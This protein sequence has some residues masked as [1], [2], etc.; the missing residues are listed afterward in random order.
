MPVTKNEKSMPNGYRLRLA[1]INQLDPEMAKLTDEDLQRKREELKARL[2][3]R[4]AA[5]STP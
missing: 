2:L 5:K 3:E 4:E 1:L